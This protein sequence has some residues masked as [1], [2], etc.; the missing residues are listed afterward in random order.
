MS[1]SYCKTA[2][3]VSQKEQAVSSTSW[4]KLNGLYQSFPSNPHLHELATLI[5][6]SSPPPTVG[7]C[8]V[9]AITSFRRMVHS[10]EGISCKSLCKRTT[11]DYH[12]LNGA[13]CGILITSA[14]ILLSPKHRCC[15]YAAALDWTEGNWCC[16]IWMTSGNS[17][18]RQP[19]SLERKR[20]RF[21]LLSYSR[22]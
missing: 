19:N 3:S 14:L 17:G 1:S 20:K 2:L 15:R 4:P 9:D 5:F 21:R 11:N 12:L 7:E 8:T 18:S 13:M 16:N 10:D 6:P 22:W